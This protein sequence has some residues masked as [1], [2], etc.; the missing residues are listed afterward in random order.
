M[1]ERHIDPARTAGALLTEHC[2]IPADMTLAEWR[3]D[4][5]RT[6]A[7]KTADPR[8]TGG[9]RRLFGRAR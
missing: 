5:A 8:P 4:A 7:E 1:T 6:E 2:D 9:L 3:R